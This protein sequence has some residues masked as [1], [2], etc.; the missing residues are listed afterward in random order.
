M[1]TPATVNNLFPDRKSKPPP[2]N[3]PLVVTIGLTELGCK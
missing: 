1:Q 3:K 2:I